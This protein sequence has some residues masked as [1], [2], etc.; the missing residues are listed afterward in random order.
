MCIFV[1]RLV[2]Q[3]QKQNPD[4]INV[5]DR[6]DEIKAITPQHLYNEI[7]HAMQ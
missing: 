5:F 4:Q 1:L 3:H 7:Q 6:Q 2:T